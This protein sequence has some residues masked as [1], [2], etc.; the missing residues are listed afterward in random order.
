MSRLWTPN[1][2]V[3]VFGWTDILEN[4]HDGLYMP[5]HV[6]TLLENL[7]AAC[8][9]DS[10]YDPP[11]SQ[12]L[13]YLNHEQPAIAW[14]LYEAITHRWMWTNIRLDYVRDLVDEI[15][16]LDGCF[17]R[18]PGSPWTS[19]TIRQWINDNL[20][21]EELDVVQMMPPLEAELPNPED[22]STPQ[23]SRSYTA[24]PAPRR[25]NR[26]Y[27]VAEEHSPAVAE[28]SYPAVAEKSYPAIMFLLQREGENENE[29]TDDKIYVFKKDNS[30]TISY[31]DG[32]AKF[33]FITNGLTRSKVISSM[34]M[35][36]RM[37]TIDE[38][39]FQYLQVSLPSMPTILIKPRDLTSQTRD[40]IYDSMEMTFDDW[41]VSV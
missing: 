41:P 14:F 31:T 9:P 10:D 40:L 18:F 24:P 26:S 28:K 5:S 6:E 15:E 37:L 33:K 8:D 13:T 36:L 7:K 27:A 21:Q 25:L 11:L 38:K 29:Q 2:N 19:K 35:M 22:Y 3:R 23:R 32:Q 1:S 16:N 12:F 4:W 39:P 17:P 20:C 30:Y 34:S